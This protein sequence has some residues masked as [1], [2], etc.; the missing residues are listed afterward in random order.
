M[1]RRLALHNGDLIDPRMQDEFRKKVQ[2]YVNYGF[3]V[4]ER[5]RSFVMGKGE[6]LV[7][8]DEEKQEF[9][10]IEDMPKLIKCN[11]IAVKQEVIPDNLVLL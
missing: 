9:V 11:K 2:F 5:E 1:N 7:E 3:K 4:V 10:H 6:V 8:W